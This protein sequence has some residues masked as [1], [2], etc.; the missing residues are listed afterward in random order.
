[1]LRRAIVKEM[2]KKVSLSLKTLSN[3]C[4]KHPKYPKCLQLLGLKVGASKH[5]KCANDSIFFDNSKEYLKYPKSGY[6]YGCDEEFAITIHEKSKNRNIISADGE[7]ILIIL[8][9]LNIP[10][11]KQRGVE[12][13]VS[14]NFARSVIRIIRK[15]LKPHAENILSIPNVL[16]WLVSFLKNIPNILNT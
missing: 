14:P 8:K 7:N 6:K 1:M 13:V 15:I 11:G 4:K 12:N 2:D 5:P 16:T 3:L 9:I 10:M